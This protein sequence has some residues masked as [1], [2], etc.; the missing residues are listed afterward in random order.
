MEYLVVRVCTA[1]EGKGRFEFSGEECSLCDGTGKEQVS[2]EEALR[3][4]QL[5]S[6]LQDSVTYLLNT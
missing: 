6:D 1:C 5:F 4:S 2:L 3:D